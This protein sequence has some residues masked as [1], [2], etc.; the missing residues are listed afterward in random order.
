MADSGQQ[1]T[2]WAGEIPDRLE[3][4]D[5]LSRAGVQIG[6]ARHVRLFTPPVSL[7]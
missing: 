1:Q 7:S 5:P 6:Y 2:C 3:V 4:G